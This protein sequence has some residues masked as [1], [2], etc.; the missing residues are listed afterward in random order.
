MLKVYTTSDFF[1]RQRSICKTELFVVIRLVTGNTAQEAISSSTSSVLILLETVKFIPQITLKN[2]H[3]MAWLCKHVIELEQD[4]LLKKLSLLLLRMVGTK[5]ESTVY[6]VLR[7]HRIY[8]FIFLESRITFKRQ[9]ICYSL[10]AAIGQSVN[11][12]HF[13]QLDLYSPLWRC[14]FFLPKLLPRDNLLLNINEETVV[15]N[16]TFY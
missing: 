5:L 1:R 8:I 11:E 7:M 14:Y 3:N 9:C 10:A 4:H 16:Y 12:N 6:I 13:E 15:F 2:S